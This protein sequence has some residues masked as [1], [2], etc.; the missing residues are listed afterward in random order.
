[1]YVCV[2][3][4]ITDSDIKEAIVNGHDSINKLGKELQLGHCCGT[5]VVDAKDI[6]ENSCLDSLRLE[7]ATIAKLN[8]L[9]YV[10]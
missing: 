3:K 10:A 6:L 4:G 1:M 7:S 8:E 9:A 2:C 5:C